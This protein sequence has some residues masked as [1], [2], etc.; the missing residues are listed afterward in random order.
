[1]ANES[2]SHLGISHCQLGFGLPGWQIRIGGTDQRGYADG[3][4]AIR[5]HFDGRVLV[6]DEPVD[7]PIDQA[8]EAHVRAIEDDPAR[9][10]AYRDLPIEKHP[11][12]GFPVFRMP[13]GSPRIT[14]Q[15]ER[16]LEDKL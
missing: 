16:R 11:I 13:P 12:T 1:M 7:L 14:M 5:V 15:D 10:G 4:T 3:K 8:L 9:K 2:T 6:A